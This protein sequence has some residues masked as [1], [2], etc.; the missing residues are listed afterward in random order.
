MTEQAQIIKRN[1]QE[2]RPMF[3]FFSIKPIDTGE[4]SM[5]Y[6]RIEELSSEWETKLLQEQYIEYTHPNSPDSVISL[7][8]VKRDVENGLFIMH[9]CR[10][11]KSISDSDIV[12]VGTKAVVK[13]TEMARLSENHA[14]LDHCICCYDFK[15]GHFV[16]RRNDKVS[17]SA[18]N[19]LLSREMHQKIK[20]NP[21]S[22]A[23]SVDEIPKIDPDKLKLS[24]DVR[25]LKPLADALE[26]QSGAGNGAAVKIL[27]R[28]EKLA[29]DFEGVE[30]DVSIRSLRNGDT[31]LNSSIIERVARVVRDLVPP[32]GKR[33]DMI[34]EGLVK[35]E[36]RQEGFMD[37]T[38]VIDIY[39]GLLA[40]EG[41]CEVE[42]GA[43]ALGRFQ[44]L[45][46]C[47]KEVAMSGRNVRTSER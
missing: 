9:F 35:D 43:T 5:F 21:I 32:S 1:T 11:N 15:N 18:I 38:R 13:I 4:L 29:D 44:D 6:R 41:D 40:I 47:I 39:N 31:S 19:Y 14:A 24:V 46:K 7:F 42:K 27:Q 16:W 45:E 12:H 17:L 3:Y 33:I 2:L 26:R 8:S 36:Y 30:I 37:E 25:G 10:Y 20:L 23:N 28:L 34:V 22:Y